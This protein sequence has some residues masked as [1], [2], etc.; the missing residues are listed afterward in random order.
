MIDLT[1]P[2]LYNMVDLD[3]L[4]LAEV[5]GSIVPGIYQKIYS[6]LDET[7]REIF[8]HWFFAG[9]V[10]PPATVVI[11][12]T[13]VGQFVINDQIVVKSNDSVY[14]IGHIY[15]PTIEPISI[16]E[17]GDYQVPI[18][19]DGYNPVEVN[20]PDIPPVLDQL[21]VSENG[22]YTPPSG[23]DGYDEVV[24]NVPDIPP[25]L[26]QLSVTENGTYTPPSG[27]DGYDEV[28]V[29]VPDTPPVLS[30]LSVTEN[31]TYTPPSGTDGY[32]EVVVN[33]PSPT[34]VNPWI[35]PDYIGLVYLY[36]YYSD[37]TI[38]RSQTQ[39]TCT[40][41]HLEPGNYVIFIGNNGSLNR[42]RSIFCYGKSFSDFSPYIN[43]PGSGVL[44]QGDQSITG[45]YER[46]GTELFVRIFFTVSQSGELITQTA[47]NGIVV[48]AYVFKITN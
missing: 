35:E 20:V 25:V 22:T 8:Y 40:F 39:A 30:Q 38:N 23:T 16:T 33:V 21:S 48:G 2:V 19:V 27:T 9:I 7:N 26:D 28:V 17:N 42:F 47:N 32:D 15:V 24:V 29:N 13:T 10:L 3:G 43:N 6:N 5:D 12:D 46:S 18:G 34:V 45:G 4:D 37:S 41:T 1:P 44:Y 11:D 31:G 36:P 14:I